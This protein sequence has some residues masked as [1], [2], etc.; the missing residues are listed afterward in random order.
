MERGKTPAFSNGE[1]WYKEN[2]QT[3]KLP[4][5]NAKEYAKYNLPKIHLILTNR[6]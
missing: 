5:T 2:G 3:L 6:N 4:Y 1:I